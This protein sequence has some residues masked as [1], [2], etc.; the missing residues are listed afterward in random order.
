MTQSQRERVL[1]RTGLSISK[2]GLGTAAFGGLY[3]HVSEAD[4]AATVKRSLE[5][6]I[7]YIDT[8]PHYGKGV[9]EERLGQIL[10]SYNRNTF[11]ISTKVGRLLS[12]ID[13][14]DDEFFLDANKKLTR[15]YDYS[16]QGIERSI[17]DSLERM[18]LDSI[19]LVF[20]HD[21]EGNEETAIY[22]AAPA[23][24][25]LRDR[26]YIKA[27]GVGMNICETPTRFINESD[28]DVVL[29]AGRYS[30][31]D[32]SSLTEL[33]PAAL[34]RG[35]DIIVAGVFN[36]GLLADPK[37][38]STY[39]YMQASDLMIDRARSL[40]TISEDFGISL[41][42]AATQFPLRN[43]AVKGVLVGC[44]SASEVEQN[45]EAFNES[46]PEEFW[47]AAGLG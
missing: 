47:R 27:I 28:I 23:L 30:L 10:K 44:R 38:G 18:Q 3:S 33:F 4:C 8:A 22:E 5:L 7:T 39:N 34:A 31:L 21:P 20:I 25:N 14:E 2:F 9:C 40:K 35:V 26:G 36:S 41:R 1:L 11:T 15:T 19:D 43:K 37:P 24:A 46:I 6:G 32:Q 45:V 17:K 29:I 13:Y 42:A 12:P 16:A